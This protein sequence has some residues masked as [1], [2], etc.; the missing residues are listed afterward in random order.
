MLMLMYII[1]LFKSLMLSAYVI[2]VVVVIVAAT[3]TLFIFYNFFVLF[4][5]KKKLSVVWLHACQKN[6]FSIFFLVWHFRLLKSI[7]ETFDVQRILKTFFYW[8]WWCDMSKQFWSG[9][10]LFYVWHLTFLK[11]IIYKNLL[12]LLFWHTF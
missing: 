11:K 3:T 6:R 7:Q 2:V 4:W 9:S 10:F 5:Q 8:Q 1:S 12:T